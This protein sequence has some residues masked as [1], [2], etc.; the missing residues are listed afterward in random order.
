[1]QSSLPTNSQEVSSR[2]TQLQ[3]TSRIRLDKKFAYKINQMVSL[4]DQI[5]QELAPDSPV[6]NSDEYQELRKYKKI[7][8]ITT[9]VADLA[10]ALANAGDFSK[11]SLEARMAVGYEQAC[12]ILEQRDE[13]EAIRQ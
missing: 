10:P 9:I 3:F 8:R 12:N 2:Q 5:D 13:A 6:R 4:L 11:S 1:M 7:D